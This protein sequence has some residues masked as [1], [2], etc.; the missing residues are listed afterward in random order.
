MTTQQEI[1][2]QI[3]ELER[4][5]PLALDVC[6]F[7]GD[8]GASIHPTSLALYGNEMGIEGQDVFYAHCDSCGAEG[9][10]AF[11]YQEA[12]NNWNNRIRD[13]K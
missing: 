11:Y 5:L 6:P 7:C 2:K 10:Q 1:R 4:E 8:G 13:L 3:A 12:I 9:P